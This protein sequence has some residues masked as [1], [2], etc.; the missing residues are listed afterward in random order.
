MP[1]R[2]RLG[3][4][5]SSS[6][7]AVS[8]H[9]RWPSPKQF[10]KLGRAPILAETVGHFHA[11]SGRDR[12]RRRRARD[13]RGAHAPRAG[14]GDASRARDGGSRRRDAPG[15]RMARAAGGSRPRGH[16]HRPRRRPASDHARP[17]RCRRAGGG[18]LGGGHL[19][20]AHHRDHQACAPGR[21]RDDARPLGAVG[22]ADASA[23]APPAPRGAREGTP[24]RRGRR[25]RDGSSGSVTRCAWGR[26]SS[27]T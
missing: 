21:G 14:A 7:R 18:R 10:I 23:F 19:R 6:R 5:R 15:L 9:A 13:P 1:E 26:G 25:R 8:G 4:W 27:R 3:S 22:G 24:G 16:H 17:H 12:G 11:T 20:P 2:R